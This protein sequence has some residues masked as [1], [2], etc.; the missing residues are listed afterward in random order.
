MNFLKENLILTVIPDNVDGISKGVIKKINSDNF[1]ICL[2]RPNLNKIKIPP[3]LEVTIQTEDCLIRFITDF[4]KI[5][6]NELCLAMPKNHK[7]IQQ[8]E[9]ARARIN[10]PVD[11][12]E[13]MNP[14]NADN[15][16]SQ[17]F[18][19]NIYDLSSGG[20]KFILNNYFNEG[21][22]FEA[23]FNVLE[24]KKIVTLIEIL[25]VDYFINDEVSSQNDKNY[26]FSA[27]FKEIDKFNR[28]AII[29]A[30]FKR[31]LELRCKE[32]NLDELNDGG[33]YYYT[34]R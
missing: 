2:D 21:T 24:N 25:K 7:I 33:E 15:T 13:I 14:N 29:Q 31:Q 5:R 4:I 12:K 30:C 17:I 1:I 3:S 32:C 9:Y 28:F 22:L 34:C 19:A 27:K 23:K 8:R 6:E 26:I 16:S 11:L 10:I 18:T 20:M